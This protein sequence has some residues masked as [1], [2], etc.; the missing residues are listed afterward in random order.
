[1]AWSPCTG[2]E[3]R[4]EDKTI[5][6]R[7]SGGMLIKM[8][9]AFFWQEQTFK[10]DWLFSPEANQVRRSIVLPETNPCNNALLDDATV[11]NTLTDRPVL[12]IGGA[13]IPEINLAGD[14]L[15]GYWHPL[16]IRASIGVYPGNTICKSLVAHAKWHE[17]S[18]NALVDLIFL[19][20]AYS[21]Q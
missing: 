15:T 21:N 13:I 2:V 3:V 14:F 18:A 16:Y 9:Y 10:G 17:Q 12:Q 4:E 6:I 19:A 20:G 11:S 1:M 7:R 5:L 8:L